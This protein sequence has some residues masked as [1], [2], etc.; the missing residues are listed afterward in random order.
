MNGSLHNISA[1]TPLICFKGRV[2]RYA[3]LMVLFDSA[4]DHLPQDPRATAVINT[5]DRLSASMWM[6]SCWMY[7]I[8][9]VPYH[10]QFPDPI[11]AF[12]PTVTLG[13]FPFDDSHDT[14]PDGS[15]TVN[16][17]LSRCHTYVS[18]Y[19][20][21][22]LLD[23][24]DPFC[25][26][27]TSGSSGQPK[28]VPLLRRQVIAA[29]RN[30]W[31]G[32][33][34]RDNQ[35]L[36]WGNAL[37]LYHAGGIS[38]LFRCFL[39]G[40]TVFLWDSF[41][42]EVMLK[43]LHSSPSV[44]DLSLVPTMLYRLVNYCEQ[45]G[46][47]L[48]DTLQRILLGGSPASE[49]LLKKVREKKWP[50]YFS[51]GMTETFGQVFSSTYSEQT[52]VGSV[53]KALPGIEMRILDD[54]G[55][56][57]PRD[58]GGTLYLSGDQV[59]D[60][61]L[62]DKASLTDPSNKAAFPYSVHSETVEKSNHTNSPP[63]QSQ[64]FDTG[65]IARKDAQGFIYIENRKSDLIITGGKKV[66]TA[67]IEKALLELGLF[68]EVAVTGVPDD[69][70]GEC[71]TA[72]VVLPP[73]ESRT[74]QLQRDYQL[75][76]AGSPKTELLKEILPALKTRLKPWEIPKALI[77]TSSIPKT[78]LGKPARKAIRDYAIARLAQK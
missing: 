47:H 12:Q 36:T 17:V 45:Q 67:D 78:S 76:Q 75:Q 71:I 63:N 35:H 52:P 13:A 59:F 68:K 19:R 18:R 38:I 6:L 66:R 9:F 70:W 33:A 27:L 5:D 25:G 43:D 44:T 26:L 72:I 50:V 39:N 24:C 8:P 30:A 28:K 31:T 1:H 49:A 10:D 29:S 23:L 61:Y 3:D 48:P 32:T 20:P 62:T 57:L 37:P 55:N 56:E 11:S 15:L 42:E 7:G 69:E 14:I 73:A 2:I 53:G 65:D 22:A 41:S 60:G 40:A 16:D 58:S 54:S 46:L 77:C 64:W 21:D 34:H 4:M 51:Y 74:A